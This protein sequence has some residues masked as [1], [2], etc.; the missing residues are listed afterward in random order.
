M[1]DALR[2]GG[3]LPIYV[4]AAIL[5]AAFNLRAGIVIVGPLVDEIRSDTG[6]SSALA[7]ALTTIPF[8][9]IGLFAFLGPALVRRF[10]YRMVI[11]AALLLITLGSLGRA[12]APT[13]ATMIVTTLPIGL[14]IALIGVTLPAVVKTQFPDRGGLVTGAYISFLS[15]GIITVGVALVP[16]AD[17]VGGWRGAFALS[18]IPPAAAA[19]LWTRPH[20]FPRGGPEVAAGPEVPPSA[21]ASGPARLRDR[22]RPD[23]AALLLGMTCGLQSVAFAGMVS[24]GPAHFQEAGWSE[25][26][27]AMVLTAIGFYTVVASLTLLPA[28]EGRDRRY[29]LVGAALALSVAL[30]WI[31]LA[32]TSLSW[33][34]LTVF[35][36]GSG[37]AFP[38]LLA[39]VLDL[40]DRPAS[41]VRLTSWM[42]GLGYLIAGL[43]PVVIGALRDLT[44]SLELPILLLAG[45]GFLSAGLALLI[46]APRQSR[47]SPTT[48]P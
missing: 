11:L 42:L 14:G 5:A 21:V 43:T 7:G 33:L 2:L 40:A 19:L 22:L 39:L 41:A 17:A 48:S 23:R 15:I 45:A 8:F 35:G 24:W 34:W 44:G 9:C 46:P 37:G 12:A 28:S 38:L 26:A 36:L 18:A 27:A 32:P 1:S 13:G 6:M 31:A 10:G 25:S 30:L 3:R 47:R 20:A 29:W 4:L 16:V